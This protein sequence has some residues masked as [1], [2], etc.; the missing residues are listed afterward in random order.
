MKFDWIELTIMMVL[1]IEYQNRLATD[2][3]L[4]G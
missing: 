2:F 3:S 1:F 4:S